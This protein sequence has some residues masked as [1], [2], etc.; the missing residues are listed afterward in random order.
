MCCSYYSVP[1]GG[2]GM[3]FDPLRGGR[4]GLGGPGGFGGGPHP[5]GQFP[6][7]GYVYYIQCHLNV[8]P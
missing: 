5:G 1:G 8:Y 6:P 7:R 2:G 3:V 4:G